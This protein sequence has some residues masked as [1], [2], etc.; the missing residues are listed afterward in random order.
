MVEIIAGFGIENL[1]LGMSV[2]QIVNIWGKPEEIASYDD[3]TIYYVW[4]QKGICCC[5]TKEFQID[6]IFFYTGLK[7]GFI[8]NDVFPYKRFDAKIQN[9][10]KMESCENE[11][12]AIL[13]NPSAEGVIDFAEIPYIWL[14]YN[15]LCFDIVIESKKIFCIS[16]GRRK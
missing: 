15:G 2:D 13:G 8:E 14:S 16:V 1:N 9:G 6:A 5:F 12:R 7:G 11:I 3:E 10:L 4:Y